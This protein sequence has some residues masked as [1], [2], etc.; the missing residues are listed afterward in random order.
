MCGGVKEKHSA[1]QVYGGVQMKPLCGLQA[2]MKGV[3]AGASNGLGEADRTI[4][5]TEEV[6]Q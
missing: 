6:A 2:L 4:A 1:H 5:G 3:A